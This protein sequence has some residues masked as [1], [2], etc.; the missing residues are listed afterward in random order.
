MNFWR[1]EALN[2]GWRG[3]VNTD[4]DRL[5][6]RNKDRK[7]MKSGCY[8]FWANNWGVA[9]TWKM[10]REEERSSIRYIVSSSFPRSLRSHTL[11]CASQREER[12]RTEGEAW[13]QSP[14]AVCVLRQEDDHSYLQD[15][16]TLMNLKQPFSVFLFFVALKPQ[17]KPYL[18]L[19][20]QKWLD[21]ALRTV[22]MN[23]QL[24][25]DQFTDQSLIAGR[26]GGACLC[27]TD[28]LEEV[29]KAR[30]AKKKEN[31]QPII[32]IQALKWKENNQ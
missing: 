5:T 9:I 14:H 23:L 29:R 28:Q 6:G 13:A 31:H 32:Q 24:S 19:K 20:T 26:S 22:S 1:H 18:Q 10:K 27:W 17:V 3:H 2:D 15:K 12:R 11:L 4:W 7:R 30:G 8:P 25:N 16:E 21:S